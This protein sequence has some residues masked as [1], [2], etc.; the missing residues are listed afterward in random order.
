MITAT[1]ARELYDANMHSVEF[2]LE[3]ISFAIEFACKNGNDSIDYII[4]C[5]T[6]LYDQITKELISKG[7]QVLGRTGSTQI[8]IG[9]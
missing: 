7:Y 6:A 8:K 9:W 5:E 4:H 3:R 2:Q 1:E